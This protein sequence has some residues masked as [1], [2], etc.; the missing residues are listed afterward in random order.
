MRGVK[1]ILAVVLMIIAGQKGWG[2]QQGDSNDYQYALI[3][4]VK[5]KNLGNLSEA[6][7]LYRLVIRDKPE[8]QVAY[9]ELGGIY[10]MS[11]QVELALPNLKIAYELD[12]ENKWYVMAYLN[13]LGSGKQYDEMEL[14]LKE[15]LKNNPEEVEWEYQLATVYLNQ[16]KQKKAIKTLERIEKEK[17]FSEKVT[18]LKA[19]IYESEEEY[20]LALVELEKVMA[21]FPEAIQFRIV[22]AE[23]CM[24]SGK[25][26]EAARY[27]L[28]MLEVD[29]TNIYALTNLTD[30]YRKIEDYDSSFIFLTKSFSS[31]MIDAQ[32]KMAILSYYLSDEKFMNAYPSQLAALVEVLIEAHPEEYDARLMATDFYIQQK[33]YDKAYWNL[34]VY[35]E[36]GGT[37]YPLYMQAILL[38]NAGALNEEL[39]S[40]SDKAMKIYP[41]SLDIR[42]F[43]GIGLYELSE[44]KAL[45]DNFKGISLEGFSSADYG[46]QAKMLYA[47]GYYRLEEYARS[48]SIFEALI[49]KEPDNYMVLNNYSY[50]LAER[51]V[52]LKEAEKWSKKAI[53]NNPDNATFLDTYAWVLFKL[54]AFEA[55]ERYILLAMEKGGENDPDV[56]EHAGDVQK[57]L[58]SYEMARSYYLKAIVLGGDREKLEEKIEMLNAEGDE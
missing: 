58:Q 32:R 21:L 22:A 8:C 7:K 9:Y 55:A 25:E 52:K 13:A 48:D 15:Q 29:S 31:N 35:L 24:K 26:K 36:K 39:V 6:V 17:G 33:K 5:Q 1:Y 40:I 57:A 2:Q 20:E 47:E 38:A 46:S 27:Y 3:E 43:R 54:E 34:K 53:D 42:F 51:G 28:D 4:A 19:S 10:L 16:E 14:I 56:N 49:E 11:N 23:L 18:L 50:Y 30:Y 44:Y 45:V 37:S 12:S 41:D